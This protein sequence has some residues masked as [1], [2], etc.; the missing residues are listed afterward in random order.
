MQCIQSKPLK[1]SGHLISSQQIPANPFL[2][3]LEFGSSCFKKRFFLQPKNKDWDNA[4]IFQSLSKGKNLHLL[5][6]CCDLFSGW[7]PFRFLHNTS[8]LLSV[9]LQA[10][11]SVTSYTNYLVH[12]FSPCS[13]FAKSNDYMNRKITIK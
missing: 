10:H 2:F 1:L 13:T 11:R 3:C 7:L 5:L 4:I 12:L 6:K 8:F 9:K